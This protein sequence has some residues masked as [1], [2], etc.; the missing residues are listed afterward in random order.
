MALEDR[1]RGKIV[2]LLER[3]VGPGKVDAAVSADL[4]FDE[5]ATTAETYDPQSQVVR[6]TQTTEEVTDQ[7]ETQPA[8]QVGA[9]GNLPTERAAAPARRARQQ[10]E[11]QQDRGDDQLRDL[12]HRPQPD[13]ARRLAAAAVDRGPGRRHLRAAAGRRR[14]PTSRARPRSSSSW[15]PWSAAPPGSTRAAATWS[16]W[17]AARSPPSLPPPEPE[18]EAGWQSMLA[19]EYG[20]LLDLGVLSLLTLL[21]LFFGV[22]PVLRRVFAAVQP[23]TAPSTTAVVLG[24]DG[25]PLLVHGATGATIGVDRAGNPVVVREAVAAESAAPRLGQGEAGHKGGELIDLKHVQG[26]VQASLLGEVARAIEA[27]PEDAVRVVRGW[28]HGG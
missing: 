14:P 10:R 20:R 13:Q 26:P 21:V 28:L 3:S 12:A 17:S 8:D 4:D 25:K 11:E 22:R 1:L 5:V 19:G 18:A 16:R 6:S 15:P 9:A 2:Q 23:A 24:A 27:N 7:Q